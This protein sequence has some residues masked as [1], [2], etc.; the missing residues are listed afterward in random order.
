[1]IIIVGCLRRKDEA[2][3]RR[4][5]LRVLLGWSRARGNWPGAFAVLFAAVCVSRYIY[6]HV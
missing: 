3:E 4:R 5:K 1:M 6:I 2:V